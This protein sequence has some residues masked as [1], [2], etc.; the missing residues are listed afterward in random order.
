RLFYQP[1][2]GVTISGGEPLLQADFTRGILELCR[3]EGIHTAIETNLA[4]PW[5]VVE[6]LASLV[7]LFLVDVKT[8]DDAAHRAWTGASNARTLENLERLDALGKTLVIRTPVIVGVNDRPEQIGAIADFLVTLR[9]VRQY[10]LLPYHPLGAGKYES[11]GLDDPRPEF[12][13]PTAVE[14]NALAATAA[15]P[16]FV[17]SVAGATAAVPSDQPEPGHTDVHNTQQPSS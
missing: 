2:G 11:L 6:R 8:M 12:H 10:E 16:G 9:N 17:V 7:D 15:R 13:A 5:E 3:R 1:A 4:W 14:L